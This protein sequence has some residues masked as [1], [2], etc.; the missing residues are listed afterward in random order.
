VAFGE[1]VARSSCS[2][3]RSTWPWCASSAG[4]RDVAA[5]AHAAGPIAGRGR[6][7][8][9]PERP[10]HEVDR[11]YDAAAISA[12]CATGSMP[13]EVAPRA[14]S[15]RKL[16]EVAMWANSGAEPCHRDRRYGRVAA[17][18]AGAPIAAGHT[19]GAELRV[20]ETFAVD[21]QL[22]VPTQGAFATWS[23]PS[24]GANVPYPAFRNRESTAPNSDEH[25][26]PLSPITVTAT[27]SP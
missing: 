22:S 12:R 16:V 24:N 1:L 3:L 8:D 25:A 15:R 11:G 14:G 6:A 21:E 18:P 19:G 10:V 2:R 17:V 13:V 5:I 4:G 20:P 23:L 27:V 26:A 9:G 7:R